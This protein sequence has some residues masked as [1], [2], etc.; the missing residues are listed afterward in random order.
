RLINPDFEV[1][2]NSSRQVRNADYFMAEGQAVEAETSRDDVGS[3][4][5][6][7]LPECIPGQT[8]DSCVP[9]TPAHY[10]QLRCHDVT[11]PVPVNN[12]FDYKYS[13]ARRLPDQ[14]AYLYENV[15]A[16]AP[17]YLHTP[18]TALLAHAEAGAFGAGA[19]VDLY[20][21]NQDSLYL[22]DNVR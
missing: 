6:L 3:F 22:D 14:F 21:D 2:T 16:S 17:Y 13:Y 18:D 8:F 4:P 15:S 7:Y 19:G 20:L 10:R 1:F 12:I 9:N 11:A 5:G